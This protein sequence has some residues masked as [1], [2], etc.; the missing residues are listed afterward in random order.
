MY[1]TFVCITYIYT[2]VSIMYVIMYICILFTLSHIPCYM[3]VHMLVC[4]YV[5]Q[6]NCVISRKSKYAKYTKWKCYFHCLHNG[7][8]VGYKHST[9][10]LLAIFNTNTIITIKLL[11]LLN[12]SN[13]TFA[14]HFNISKLFFLYLHSPVTFF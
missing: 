11:L 8:K 6:H 3:Y 5:E 13:Y 12:S 9:I 7:Y 1:I 2:S 4:I 10:G 14:L